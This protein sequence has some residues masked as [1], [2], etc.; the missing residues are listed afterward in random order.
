MKTL[1]CFLLCASFSFAADAP[2][3]F[4]DPKP[5]SYQ[6]TAR[7]SEL[8]SRCRSYTEIDNV[9][10]SKPDKSGKPADLQNA[11]VD[12]R[13]AP[14]GQLV[15]WLMAHNQVHADLLNSYGLHYIQV[16]YARDWFSKL[17]TEPAD[18]SQHLG[19]I[20]LEAT[21]GIDA[22]EAIDVP[23]ADSMQEHA[24][25]FVKS[26][27]KTHP[28]GRW[29]T[30]LSKDGT[31]LD[32]EK[33]I[34]AGASHGATSSARFGLHQR[35]ARVVMHCGP[36]DNA[37]DWQA[38]PSATP[39]NRFFGYSHVLDGGW[40]A[41]HYERSWLLL[42]LNKFGPIV[43]T[44]KAKPPYGNTRRLITDAALKGTAKEQADR[45][46]GYVTP[47]KNSPREESGKFVQD[48]VWRYLYTSPVDKVG[49]P[50]DPEPGVKM[51]Q[52]KKQ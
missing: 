29:E 44:E 9:F 39:K 45:G 7:A 23:V 15:L 13:V 16:W 26:L 21:T 3:K 22:S 32:W 25:Q 31:T 47:S 19:N 36:R 33:V 4:N 37:D 43:N 41:D 27:A 12:T 52:R 50:V 24:F 11:S 38:L 14:R 30:F 49:K 8:D 40:T 5:K 6:L 2:L 1:Y 34:V 51:D 28:Q 20:R 10:V 46:H 42:G 48:A 35:V 17:N 18:D